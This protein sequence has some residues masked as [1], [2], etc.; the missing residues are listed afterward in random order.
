MS[1]EPTISRV[2]AAFDADSHRVF[3]SALARSR[4]GVLR[5]ADLRSALADEPMP[6]GPADVPPMSNEPAVREW[7]YRA[8]GRA[9]TGPLTPTHLREAAPP[10]PAARPRPTVRRAVDR[11]AC[12]WLAVRCRTVQ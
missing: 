4:G 7:L 5:L 11:R 2:Y 9:G 3:R 6:A 8:Y 12:A 1:T 10:T